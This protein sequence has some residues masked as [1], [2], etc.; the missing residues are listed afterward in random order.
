MQLSISGTSPQVYNITQGS[1][2][3]TITIDSA[4]N[5]T[6]RVVWVP[7]KLPAA[8]AAEGSGDMVSCARARGG[9]S[10][11]RPSVCHPLWQAIHL[12]GP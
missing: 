7:V 10:V 11:R 8:C 4:A 6:V 9:E 2:V 1:T 3:A 12:T 5:T